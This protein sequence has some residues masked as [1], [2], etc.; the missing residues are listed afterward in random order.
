MPGILG[1][2]K[3]V[4]AAAVVALVLTA[5]GSTGSKPTGTATTLSPTTVSVGSTA[6]TTSPQPVTGAPYELMWA[7]ALSTGADKYISAIEKG[8]DAR[9]GIA[10]HPLQIV[11]CVDNAVASQATQCAR[12]AVS[13]PRMLGIIANTSTCSSQLLSILE[14]AQMASIG[15]Q[16]FCPEDYKSSVVFPF[17]AGDLTLGAG[18]TLAAEQFHSS[19]VVNVTIDVPA[20][21][22]GTADLA[23]VVGSRAKVPGVY[24]PFTAADLAPFAAQV[25]QDGGILVEGLTQSIGIRLGQ[26]LKLQ[27]YD[28]PI[29]YNPS[30]FDAATISA[31]FHDPTNAYLISAYNLSSTGFSMFNS[32]METYLPTT[33]YRASDLLIAWLAANI[34]AREANEMSDPTAS[35]VLDSLRSATSLNTY[36]LTIPLNYTMP[37]TFLG[38]EAP[39]VANPCV[40]LYHYSNGAWTLN[41][42][43]KDVLDPPASAVACSS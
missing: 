27:G 19:T 40:A 23:A 13:N 30:T 37:A 42:P 12:Q 3:L 31:N 39:R 24:I 28:R 5:C 17:D 32:D 10:G 16:F 11:P 4:A 38:G 18:A 1:R 43:F 14:S 2:W 20:G 6:P 35:K 36:G 33:T 26:A 22:Q 15:D 41:G 25:V 34:V 29:I 7:E 8:V 9:G 21:H